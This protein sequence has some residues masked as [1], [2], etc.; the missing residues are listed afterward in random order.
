M[1]ISVST[2]V[3]ETAATFAKPVLSLV[4]GSPLRQPF[5]GLYGDWP[6]AQCC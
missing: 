3:V 5:D 4:E 2:L 1:S 6:L